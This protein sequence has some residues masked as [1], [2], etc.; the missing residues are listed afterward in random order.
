[1]IT[2]GILCVC[3][4]GCCIV[5]PMIEGRAEQWLEQISTL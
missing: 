1:M 2:L 4:V 3:G 5:G